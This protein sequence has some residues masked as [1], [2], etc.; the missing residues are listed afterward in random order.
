MINNCKRY[1]GSMKTGLKV[2]IVILSTLF[3]ILLM[4]V[5]SHNDSH[6]QTTFSTFTKTNNGY[7]LFTSA[8][9]PEG[10][11]YTVHIDNKTGRSVGCYLNISLP[12]GKYNYTIALP[13]DYQANLSSG[14]VVISS[15]GTYVPFSV[16]Y[17]S[18]SFV[19]VFLGTIVISLVA[20]LVTVWWYIKYSK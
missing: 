14:S 18:Y 9:L 20:I 8:G 11:N 3:L 15:N 2:R 7:V 19:D 16:T 6:M 5:P 4:G 12:Y 1:Y 17:R 10:L 13:Y